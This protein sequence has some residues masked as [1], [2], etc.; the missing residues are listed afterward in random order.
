MSANALAKAGRVR[1]GVPTVVEGVKTL[2]DIRG[3]T[4][5]R[6]RHDITKAN[7][8]AISSHENGRLVAEDSY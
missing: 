5:K 4:L 6:E 8:Q 3:T 2:L 7:M 1:Q